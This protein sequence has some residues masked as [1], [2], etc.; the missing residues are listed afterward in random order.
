MDDGNAF[1]PDPGDGPAR[2]DDDLAEELAEGFLTSAT[3][4]EEMEESMSA[5]VPE[6]DGGPYVITTERQE[7][8]KGVDA[9]NP[10][11]AEVAAFPSPMRV[12][13]R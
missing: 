8:A 2:M 7:L 13:E 11:D 6:D 10:E 12:V 9:S 4:G 5:D 3:A 1:L